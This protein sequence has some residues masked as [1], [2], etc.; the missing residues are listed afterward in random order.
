MECPKKNKWDKFRHPLHYQI[1]DGGKEEDGT[2]TTI[3]GVTKSTGF[4]D[5]A[6]DVID[7]ISRNDP[8][9][10]FNML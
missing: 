8:K 4:G 9:R 10:V 5:M 3:S 6:K 2:A 1:E 7:K